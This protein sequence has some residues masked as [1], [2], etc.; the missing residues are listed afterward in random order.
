MVFH[1]LPFLYFFFAVFVAYWSLKGTA[2]L[3][4][5]L[6]SSAVFYAWW[7]YRFVGLIAISTIV[8]FV[9]ARAIHHHSSQH[10]LRVLLLTSVFANL[11]ILGLFKYMN[12]FGE[13]A[14]QF[15]DSIGIHLDWPTLN[16]ILPLGISF[17]TFQ[18]LSY[19]IDVYRRV[20]RPESSL[21]KFAV[22][23][24]F[25]PQLVAG[26]IVRAAEFLP[27]LQKDR[28]LT[29]ENCE[30]GFGLVLLGLFQK[31]VIAD[32]IAILVDN[33]FGNPSAYTA[34]NTVVVV[35]EHGDRLG[36]HAWL[37]LPSQLSLS[38]F[39]SIIAG[40]LAAMAYLV[41][42]M[43]ARLPLHSLGR[44]SKGGVADSKKRIGDDDPWGTLAWGQY[45]LSSLGSD[46]RNFDFAG[47]HARSFITKRLDQKVGSHSQTSLRFLHRVH[48]V[49]VVSQPKHRAG[50]RC[51]SSNH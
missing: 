14:V 46:P 43:A 31:V 35:F 41:V 45:H 20:I 25:F 48:H 8:D 36:A 5:C 9:L 44:K 6:V 27:Q 21:L 15:A 10:I 51:L 16:L 42:S 3:W 29:F 26:P 39:R 33:L 18:T 47:T 34:V 1:S 13:Q 24:T 23:V 17:Y 37:C 40:I 38:L 30:R 50:L 28:C 22:Y 7:D 11:G 49:G 2:R 19:T 4:L 32:G 12:F